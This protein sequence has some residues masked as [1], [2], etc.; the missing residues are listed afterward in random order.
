MKYLFFFA[1]ALTTHFGHSEQIKKI[2]FFHEVNLENV[3]S[4]SLVLSDQDAGR[5]AP[6]Q[7]D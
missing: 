3:T 6:V 2:S 7:V 5:K 4:K 1:F